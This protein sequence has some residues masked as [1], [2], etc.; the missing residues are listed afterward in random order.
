M[1]TR[2]DMIMILARFLFFGEVKKLQRKDNRITAAEARKIKVSDK[3][4]EQNLSY[5]Y[6]QVR[7]ASEQGYHKCYWLCM[8]Y[9]NEVIRMV[10]AQLREDGYTLTYDSS[11]KQL[12]I[13]W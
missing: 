6:D 5:I 2:L 7:T 3:L 4:V 9:T 13:E 1:V 8:V 12:T 11:W 10:M